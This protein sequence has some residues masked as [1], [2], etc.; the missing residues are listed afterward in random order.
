MATAMPPR[1]AEVASSR[2]V[3]QKFF[4]SGGGAVSLTST[5]PVLKAA[6][7]RKGTAYRNLTFRSASMVLKGA[8]EPP[9]DTGIGIKK[10]QKYIF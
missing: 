10:V 3:R 2:L 4:G 9:K 1:A 7:L 6:N 5:G 8:V